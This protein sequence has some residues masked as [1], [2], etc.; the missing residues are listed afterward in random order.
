MSES[1]TP[2]QVGEA[3]LFLTL[4]RLRVEL[5]TPEGFPVFLSDLHRTKNLN[6]KTNRD[7]RLGFVRRELSVHDKHHC[8]EVLKAHADRR[9]TFDLR[10]SPRCDRGRA[11]ELKIHGAPKGPE[12]D[13]KLVGIHIRRFRHESSLESSSTR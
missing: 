2:P 4:F 7:M 9:N 10:E 11:G 13:L 3:K 6:G 8:L 5:W 12:V 1:E